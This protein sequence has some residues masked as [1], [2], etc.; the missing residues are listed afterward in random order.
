MK[1]MKQ[2]VCP[3]SDERTNEQVTRIN[4]LFGILLVVS[5]FVFNSVFFFVFLLADFYIRAFTK[6]KF[7]PISFA[8]HSMVNALNLNKKSID[9]APKNFAARMGFLMT[10]AITLLFLFQLNTAAFVVGGILVFFAA[11]EFALAICV[12]CIMYTYLVLPFYK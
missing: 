4:A 10:L 7:S 11:L 9:K 1:Q 12:G 5:G 8:G 6:A 3:I 2:I